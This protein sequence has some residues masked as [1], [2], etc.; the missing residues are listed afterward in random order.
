VEAP[1]SNF[2]KEHPD[3]LVNQARFANVYA[4]LGQQERGAAILSSVVQKREASKGD[5]QRTLQDTQNLVYI[6]QRQG[7][8]EDAENMQADVVQIRRRTVGGH[9]PDTIS[10]MAD[11]TAI[12]RVQHKWRHADSLGIQVCQL[13]NAMLG[14]DHP[15]TLDNMAHLDEHSR[16]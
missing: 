16:N 9:H 5:H 13:S 10:S 15:T 3:T 7:R 8:W 1:A 2:N 11:L 14:T 12:Y 4:H 6:Y